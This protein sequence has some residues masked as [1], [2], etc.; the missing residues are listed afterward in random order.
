MTNKYDL[1]QLIRKHDFLVPDPESLRLT[2]YCDRSNFTIAES[3]SNTKIS[4]LM[5]E[6]VTNKCVT[7]KSKG[8]DNMGMGAWHSQRR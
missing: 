6:F 3:I 5:P 8:N 7:N 4:I 2:R 1:S